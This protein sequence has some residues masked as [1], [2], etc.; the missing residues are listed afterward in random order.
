MTL[1]DFRCFQCFAAVDVFTPV[2][3]YDKWFF[4]VNPALGFF[5][6]MDNAHDGGVFHQK[7]PFA[8]LAQFWS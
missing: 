7:Y 5:A 1:I 6:F 4:L 8:W 3:Q 2:P